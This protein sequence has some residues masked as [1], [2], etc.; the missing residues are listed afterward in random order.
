MAQCDALDGSPGSI[1]CRVRC[2]SLVNKRTLAVRAR[3]YL[4]TSVLSHCAF[5][6]SSVIDPYIVHATL[7]SPQ[8]H[9]C[10]RP[11]IIA[12]L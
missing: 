8:H 4:G 7:C 1:G 10:R 2:F 5:A 11:A 9:L 6:V 3:G 12:S